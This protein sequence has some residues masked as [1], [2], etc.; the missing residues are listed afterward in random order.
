MKLSIYKSLFLTLALVLSWSGY[1]QAVWIPSDIS[2]RR[3]EELVG[4]SYSYEDTINAGK[5]IN[6]FPAYSSRLIAA[7]IDSVLYYYGE[8]NVLRAKYVFDR[9]GSN[10]RLL[11]GARQRGAFLK[12]ISFLENAG[13]SGMDALAGLVQG[14][15]SVWAM[16]CSQSIGLRDAVERLESFSARLSDLGLEHLALNTA[17]RRAKVL[18][19]SG[20]RKEAASLLAESTGKAEGMGYFDDFVLLSCRYIDMLSSGGNH[21]KADSLFRSALEYLSAGKFYSGEGRLALAMAKTDEEKRSGYIAHS[22]SLFRMTDD[23]AGLFDLAL[24]KLSLLIGEGALDTSRAQAPD[25]C[26]GTLDSLRAAARPSHASM[27]EYYR[28]KAL[29][30]MRMDSLEKAESDFILSYVEFRSAGEMLEQA[31]VLLELARLESDLRKHVEVLRYLFISEGIYRYFDVKDG[32]VKVF[33]QRAIEQCN[34]CKIGEAKRWLAR[35]DGS[36]SR[37]RKEEAYYLI[38]LVRARVA[39]ASGDTE[40]A[41]KIRLALKGSK[42]GESRSIKNE[43]SIADLYCELDELDK[44]DS[45]LDA[46]SPALKSRMSMS[47]WIRYNLIKG[48]VLMKRGEAEK[49]VVCLGAAFDGCGLE[50][51]ANRQAFDAEVGI[52]AKGATYPSASSGD[53]NRSDLL[54]Y[55]AEAGY[56]LSIAYDSLGRKGLAVETG[57]RTIEL[58]ELKRTRIQTESMK[59]SFLDRSRKIYRKQITRLLGGGKK[60]HRLEACYT[61]SYLKGRVISEMLGQGSRS[62]GFGSLVS[63]S[64]L[65]ERERIGERIEKLQRKARSDTISKATFE[66][67]KS[68]MDRALE[69]FDRLNRQINLAAFSNINAPDYKAPLPIFY[70]RKNLIPDSTAV[71]QYFLD[72]TCSWVFVITP[73]TLDVFR[74]DASKPKIKRL[75]E[76][77]IR[78]LHDADNYAE[79]PFDVGS[80]RKLYHILIGPVS[81]VLKGLGVKQ[82]IIQRDASLNLLPFELLV[83]GGSVAE[84]SSSKIYYEYRNL[85]FL[86]D[87]CIVSYIPSLELLYDRVGDVSG[88]A[89]KG[90]LCIGSPSPGGNEQLASNNREHLEQLKYAGAELRE[91]AGEFGGRLIL[92]ANATESAFKRYASFYRFVHVATHARFCDAHPDSSYLKFS[93]ASDGEDGRLQMREIS[94]MKIGAT[95]LFL[96]ACDTGEGKLLEDEGLIGI[97]RAF[98]YAGC[99]NM[100]V[101]QW[102]VYDRTSALLA[103]R[104]YSNLKAR[105]LAPANAL[106]EAKKELRKEHETINGI[107]IYYYNPVFWAPSIM[108]GVGR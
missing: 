26:I 24:Y 41:L 10:A 55:E 25:D 31:R 37:A 5:V 23:A 12:E 33:C 88:K 8:G 3:F 9:A 76:N 1:A 40:K 19:W 87:D 47:S 96:N 58:L 4:N 14:A 20:R 103:E 22:D 93:V 62:S 78:P 68:K 67:L 51:G 50:K 16:I 66:E 85:N 98:L 17:L 79:V 64:L 91:V 82:L 18:Q 30:D 11:E 54:D 49:A 101:N 7:G 69:E 56:Y 81:D 28:L 42:A 71:L 94:S 106:R 15:D 61:L 73:D 107:E 77:V 83:S 44:A 52:A 102:R 57:R 60:E 80:S 70:V 84:G 92:G 38:N 29:L 45:L 75:V 13:T 99:R 39:E 97:A 21:S 59:Y 89:R 63:D 36:A 65:E 34:E 46:L 108:V 2:Y 32:L 35:A 72:K 48:K 74:L 43:L 100:V 53:C 86:V 27:G 90:L 6:A 95:L 105:G 104:F